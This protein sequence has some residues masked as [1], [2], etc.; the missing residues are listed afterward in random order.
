LIHGN[1]VAIHATGSWALL[2]GNTFSAVPVET[3][4]DFGIFVGVVAGERTPA[5]F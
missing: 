4:Q 2:P 1:A 3:S 5:K